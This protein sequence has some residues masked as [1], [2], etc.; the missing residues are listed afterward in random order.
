MLINIIMFTLNYQQNGAEVD[1][2]LQVEGRHQASVMASH[3]AH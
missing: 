3:L 2:I 1:A